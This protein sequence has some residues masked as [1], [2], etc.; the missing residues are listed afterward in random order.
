MEHDPT[1]HKCNTQGHIFPTNAKQLDVFAIMQSCAPLRHSG[2]TADATVMAKR[3][4][5]GLHISSHVGVEHIFANLAVK[6]KVLLRIGV[7]IV[8]SNPAVLHLEELF[9]ATDIR[10]CIVRVVTCLR[11][12]EPSLVYNRTVDARV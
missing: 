3:L 2:G 6:P 8:T 4:H 11:I 10:L 12:S 5:D 1:H 9:E 7:R